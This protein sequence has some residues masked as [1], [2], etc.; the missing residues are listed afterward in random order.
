[1]RGAVS[2][3]NPKNRVINVALI[4]RLGKE[5]KDLNYQQESCTLL[6][7][8]CYAF[9]FTEALQPLTVQLFCCHDFLTI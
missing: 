7:V 2:A 9:L 5:G 6:F 1:M 3:V 8:I 4:L